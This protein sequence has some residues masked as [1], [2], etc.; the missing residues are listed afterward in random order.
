[1]SKYDLM[2]DSAVA[3]FRNNSD[4]LQS[5]FDISSGKSIVSSRMMEWFVQVY[6]KE[7][8]VILYTDRKGA[9][10]TKVN[11]DMTRVNVHLDF[12][13]CL[14]NHTKTYFDAFRRKLRF[15]FIAD[16]NIMIDTTL[17]QMNFV[18]W[19]FQNGIYQYM[20]DKKQELLVSF[21]QSKGS[22][23]KGI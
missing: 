20:V 15:T 14:K 1:M 7:H 23:R 11:R 21:S 5:L 19:L 4:A 2:L 17:A 16:E 22:R 9:Y 13:S 3:Y 6:T 12:K 8:Q 18:R 10:T